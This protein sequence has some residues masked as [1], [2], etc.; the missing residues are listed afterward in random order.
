MAGCR[1]GESGKKQA[2]AKVEAA[3]AEYRA[4]HPECSEEDINTISVVSEKAKGLLDIPEARNQLTKCNEQ[5]IN[6]N[7]E[8][9]LQF[10][11]V[12]YRY[13]HSWRL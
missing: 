6:D 1:N 3:I 4:A 5:Y 2:D 12:C 9:L 7:A 11:N 10:L 8:T 13:Q